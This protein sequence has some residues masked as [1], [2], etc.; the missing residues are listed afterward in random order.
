MA[1]TTATPKFC[2]RC[3]VRVTRSPADTAPGS[4]FYCDACAPAAR[5]V[6][7]GPA[8]RG[9]PVA[10]LLIAVT[11]LVAVAAVVF[12]YYARSADT[13]ADQSAARVAVV[14]PPPAA[15]LAVPAPVD[16]VEAVRASAAHFY[17]FDMD[18]VD[19]SARPPMARDAV[20]ARPPAV[21]RGAAS[22]PDAR[23]GALEF[24]GAGR[25]VEVPEPIVDGSG[26]TMS[27]AA[28]V[29]LPRAGDG[30]IVDHAGWADRTARGYVLRVIDGRAD[31]TVGDGAEWHTV[32][33]D[34]PVPVG[35]WVHLAATYGGG[36]GRLYVDGRLAATGALPRP[37]PSGQPTWVGCGSFAVAR[38]RVFPGAIAEVGI[39]DRALTA[40]E[41]RLLAATR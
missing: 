13:A 9:R 23:G 29:R 11:A 15:A 34:G 24:G 5:P 27:V 3:G 10:R 26:G 33:G 1:T 40:D 4:G 12:L 8:V 28:W 18:A 2:A 36:V 7:D 16:T 37:V 35:R 41:V 32:A 25:R 22:I 6:G 17:T 38:D 39:F 31:F 19:W 14:S 30:S 20:A 21:I